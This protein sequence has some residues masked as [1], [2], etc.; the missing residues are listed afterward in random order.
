MLACWGQQQAAVA[1]AWEAPLIKRTPPPPSPSHQAELVAPQLVLIVPHIPRHKLQGRQRSCACWGRQEA[2]RLQV[3]F[4]G[5]A[6]ATWCHQAAAAG[7]ASQGGSRTAPH[8][9]VGVVP[10][11]CQLSQD[12]AGAATAAQEEREKQDY[13]PNTCAAMQAGATR[14]LSPLPPP[15]QRGTPAVQA[16]TRRL[17]RRAA[18]HPQRRR[19]CTAQRGVRSDDSVPKGGLQTKRTLTAGPQSARAKRSTAA[20]L[21]PHP[22]GPAPRPPALPSLVLLAEYVLQAH[23]RRLG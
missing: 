21:S 5:S 2:A 12:L 17:G 6:G 16:L 22:A 19:A 11:F 10:L 13:R 9:K 7:A 18:R 23:A 3:P 20:A 8:A 14:H 4:S 15:L 1:W